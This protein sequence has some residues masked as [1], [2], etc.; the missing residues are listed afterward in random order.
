MLSRQ[1]SVAG[2]GRPI[3]EDEA[4][5][6]GLAVEEQVRAL[7]RDVAGQVRQQP[8]APCAR[9]RHTDRAMLSRQGGGG[10]AVEVDVLGGGGGGGPAVEVDAL[11]EATVQAYERLA[12]VR[13]LVVSALAGLGQKLR[14]LD[15]V[16]KSTGSDSMP[17]NVEMEINDAMALLTGLRDKIRACT[18]G[19][20]GDGAA[21][22]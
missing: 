18:E 6:F 11:P 21:G 13:A 2:G 1:D 22:Q 8:P 10:P 15:M 19:D 7:M 5:R 20:G 17:G 14:R 3:T 12:Q 16:S 9:A 4:A